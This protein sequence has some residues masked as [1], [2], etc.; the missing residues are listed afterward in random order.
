MMMNGAIDGDAWRVGR[1]ERK[2]IYEGDR[3]AGLALTYEDAELIVAA[4]NAY[5]A[6]Q[7]PVLIPDPRS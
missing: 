6:H 1:E 2:A 4:V 5:R 3:F 7:G